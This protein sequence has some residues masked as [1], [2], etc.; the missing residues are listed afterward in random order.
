ML[1]PSSFKKGPRLSETKWELLHQK[2]IGTDCPELA[3]CHLLEAFEALSPEMIVL[4]P[5][6][7]GGYYLIGMGTDRPELF[8][9]IDWST[10]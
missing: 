9:G 2:R 6:L 8:R 5:A 10:E 1:C 7:D 4:G 3:P